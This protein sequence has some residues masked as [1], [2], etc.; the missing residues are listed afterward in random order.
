ML[1]K[2]SFV[3]VML[4]AIHFVQG[5]DQAPISATHGQIS[6]Q[7]LDNA[8]KELSQLDKRLNGQTEKYLRGVA[9]EEARLKTKLQK[10][11]STSARNLFGNVDERYR[12]LQAGLT[13]P[14]IGLPQNTTSYLPSIDTLKNTLLFL[15]TNKEHLQ[16]PSGITDARLRATIARARAL[17][18]K[19][20]A[21]GDLKNTLDQRRQYLSQEL[22][23]YGLTRNLSAMNK[24]VYYYKQQLSDWKATLKDP[25]RLQQKAT[26]TLS[27]IPAYQRFIRQHSYLASVFGNLE[28]YQLSDSGMQGLQTRATVQKMIQDKIA[29]GGPGADQ[30]VL[31]QVQQAGTELGELKNKLLQLGGKEEP[32]DPDFKPNSQKTKSFWRRLE[33]GANFQFAPASGILPTLCDLGLSLGYKLH[34]HATAGL[35]LSYKMGLGDGLQHI[36]FSSQGLGLRSFIDWKIEKNLFL[37]GGYERNHFSQFRSIDQLRDLSQW[38]QS[39]LIG[40]SRQYQLSSKIKGKLQLL[41]DFLSYQQVPR[42]TPILFRTGWSF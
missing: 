20:N 13:S 8:D 16:L 24:Q 3:A 1:R 33:Y 18:D 38:Q 27:Q 12:R 28:D 32:A 17:Q 21:A 37:S 30:K 34:D 23:K 7:Y 25:S 9:R 31:Q 42:S 11:D 2:Y 41:F 22:G 4:L 35:G 26:Q 40:L 36:Q 39:G 10:I 14:G 15:Q 5:Q 19:V 6:G 29:T